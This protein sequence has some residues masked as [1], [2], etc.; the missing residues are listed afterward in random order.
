MS[1]TKDP[2][3]G[4]L[5]FPMEIRYQRVKRG[6]GSAVGVGKA[7]QMSSRE[8]LFTTQHPLKQGE[9]VRLAVD[10]PAMLEKD[11]LTKLEIR[12]SVVQ[13][14]PGRAA[15]GIASYI[16]TESPVSGLAGSIPQ[17]R[18]RDVLRPASWQPVPVAQPS[19]AGTPLRRAAAEV[20]VRGQLMRVRSKETPPSGGRRSHQ[21]ALA[22]LPEPRGG[23]R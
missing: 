14:E 4:N 3:H 1:K 6:R 19:G 11:C 17:M 22:G 5:Q 10:W 13:S 12:G 8:I 21:R 18:A 2:E 9:R 7:L 16:V 20:G 23:G 15:V